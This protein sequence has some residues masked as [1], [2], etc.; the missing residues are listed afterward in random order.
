M[1]KEFTLQELQE[2]VGDAV[3]DVIASEFDGLCRDKTFKIE[4][5]YEDY[6]DTSIEV[7]Q[8][9]GDDDEVEFREDTEKELDVDTI[10]EKL[11]EDNNFREC[12]QDLIKK[13]VWERPLEV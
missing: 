1:T 3:F 6:G 9:I 8:Y 7:A 5:Q 4:H 11:K 12:V 13:I 2:F 10:I